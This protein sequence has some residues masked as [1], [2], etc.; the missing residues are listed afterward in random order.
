MHR[1]AFRELGLEADYTVVRVAENRRADLETAV[2]YLAASGGGN[3]TVPHKQAVAAM[4]HSSSEDVRITGACNCFWSDG[5]GGIVGDNTDVGGILAVLRSMRRLDPVGATVLIVGAG[6][7]AAAAA[8]AAD[9]AGAAT[10][11]VLNR[12]ADR[13]ASLVHRLD[14][15]S[16]ATISVAPPGTHP[17]DFDLVIQATSLGLDP[18]DPLP[19]EFGERPPAYALDLVYARG[20]TS[21]VRHARDG[22]SEAIDGLAILWEQGVLSLERWLGC[23]VSPSV[24]SAMWESLETAAR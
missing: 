19:C 20:E 4:L 7:G 8:V 2:G 10:I 14:R 21:W 12:R 1:A 9:R 3:V 23:P 13:A 17:G 16:S 11:S 6:G 22:G 15:F 18:A 24:R 5:S